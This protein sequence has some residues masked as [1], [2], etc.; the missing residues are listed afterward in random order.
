MVS[1]HIHAPPAGSSTPGIS[2]DFEGA[3]GQLKIEDF[4]GARGQLKLLLLQG[5]KI[6]VIGGTGWSEG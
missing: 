5:V 4:E 3:R 2:E 1:C 6:I